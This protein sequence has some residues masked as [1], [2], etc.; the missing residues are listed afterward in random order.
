MLTIVYTLN[1]DTVSINNMIRDRKKSS[2]AN[3][4]SKRSSNRD[5]KQHITYDSG[6]MRAHIPPINKPYHPI[7]IPYQMGFS[8]NTGNIIDP[9][10]AQSGNNYTQ[11]QIHYLSP[12][13]ISPSQAISPPSEVLPTLSQVVPTLSQVVPISSQVVPTSSQIVPISSQVVPTS[14]QIVPTSSQVVPI[15]SQVVPTSSQVVPISSQV[16]PTSSQVVNET[17]SEDVETLTRKV[18]PYGVTTIEDSEDDNETDI[19]TSLSHYHV[20]GGK[21]WQRIFGYNRGTDIQ[22]LCIMRSGL[23]YGISFTHSGIG[24]IPP[25]SL[26]ICKNI[27]RSTIPTDNEPFV[28]GIIHIDG[29]INNACAFTLMPEEELSL[30]NDVKISW[31][32]RY[33]SDNELWLKRGDRISIYAENL[34]GANIELYVEY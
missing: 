20:A 3:T 9:S 24:V 17:L 5:S 31:I 2:R 15:S 1:H 6:A 34:S 33:S 26:Y 7:S 32:P 22:P 13:I 29:M 18:D 30:V 8:P 21:G 14:S 25:S 19:H 28:I 10:S 12:Q 16:V 23:L 27:E 11:P 4:T